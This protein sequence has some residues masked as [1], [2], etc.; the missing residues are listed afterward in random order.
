MNIQAKDWPYPIYLNPTQEELQ[1]LAQSNWDTLRILLT[2]DPEEL[3]IASGLGNSYSSM[4]QALIKFKNGILQDVDC[5]VVYHENNRVF[6][7][8]EDWGGEEQATFAN[9]GEVLNVHLN[10]LKNL[11]ELAGLAL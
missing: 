7:N 5:F 11:V 2:P 4:L 9:W 3:V 1:E 6:M 10:T 8:L